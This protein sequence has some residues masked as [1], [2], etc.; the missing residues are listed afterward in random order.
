M[1]S[2]LDFDST[3][4]FRKTLIGRTL[5]QPNGPQT[6]S[7]NNYAYASLSDSSD[8]SGGTIT[9]SKTAEL[10]QSQAVNTYK[11]DSYYEKG[12]Q[13]L[14]R[15]ANL[16]LYPYFQVSE[17]NLVGILGNSD[18]YSNES[19]LYKFAVSNILNNPAGPVQQRIAQNINASA[20]GYKA[21]SDNLK[22]NSSTTSSIISGKQPLVNY[23]KSIT[24]DP[25]SKTDIVDFLEVLEGHKSYEKQIP[26][27]Y[28]TDPNNPYGPTPTTKVGK[29]VQ[30]VTGVL[31]AMLGVQSPYML[32]N[33]PSD[34][35]Y[36]YMGETQKQN[37]LDNLSYNRYAPDYSDTAI[38]IT[39]K[40][41]SNFA[42]D[43]GRSILNAVGLGNPPS[44]A[45]IG[46]DR[47][48]SLYYAMNDFYDRPVLSTYYLSL[49]F[50]PTQARLL[51]KDTN[52]S[53]GG[54][55]TG[56]LTWLSIN[57]KKLNMLGANNHEWNAQNSNYEQTESVNFS[58]KDG[59]ILSKTQE[60]LD[61]LPNNGGA[62]R[63][64]VANAIDQT[65]RI[66]LDGDTFMARGSAVQYTDQ[67]GQHKGVEYCRTWTKDRPY[68]TYDNLMPLAANNNDI[69]RQLYV[70]TSKPY[71]RTNVRRYDSSVMSNTWNLNIAPMSDGNKGFKD[72]TNIFEKTPGKEDFYAKKYMFSIENLA[73]K[74]SNI[75]GFTV[76]D[77]PYA[78]VGPNGGRVMW[79]APYDL[80]VTE[81]NNA[82]W[83]KN[84]FV[85]RPEPIYTY[86][87]TE[88]SGTLSFK[89]VVDHPSILNLLVR[90][91]FKGVP[92]D[93]ADN[94]INAYFAGCQDLDFYTLVRKYTNINDTDIKL[95][96]AYLNKGGDPKTIIN[97]KVKTTP[98]STKPQPPIAPITKTV[99]QTIKVNMDYPNDVPHS[100]SQSEFLPNQ[101]YSEIY[102]I[103]S[104]GEFQQGSI[105]GLTEGMTKISQSP[106]NKNKNDI[107]VL[108]GNSEFNDYVSGLT[109]FIDK[110]TSSLNAAFANTETSYQDFTNGL[111]KI[112]TD[113]TDGL[114]SGQTINVN[115]ESSTSL[116]ADEVYNIKLSIRRSYSIISTF[117]E[118]VSANGAN[119]DTFSSKWLDMLAANPPL[120]EG[121]YTPPV[122][123]ITFEELGYPNSN[124]GKFVFK[125]IND[126]PS[127]TLN[128]FD[129][130]NGK[131]YD[132][133]LKINS[134][135]AYGCRQSTVSWSYNEVS[136]INHPA[137][138]NNGAGG[139]LPTTQIIEDGKIVPGA[140]PHKPSI[141]TIKKIIGKTLQESYY[142]KKIEETDPIVF[143][144]LK[145]K[146][147]Y[148]HPAFHSTTP[149]GLNSRLTFLQ[150]CLR[151]GDTIPVST[152]ADV[153]DAGARN[154]SFGPPP[155]CVLR[156][157]DF[158]HSK[159]IIENMNITYDDNNWDL[160]PDGIGVQP[161]IATVQLSIK[162][163]GGQ[164]LEEPVNRLQNALSSNFYA[165]TEMYDDRAID[166]NTT[167]GGQSVT[168]FTKTFLELLVGPSPAAP[169]PTNVGTDS[170]T[171]QGTYIGN[172]SSNKID[173]K[174]LIGTLYK[175]V[176]AYTDAYQKMY[177]TLLTKYGSYTMNV[178]LSTSIRNYIAY[179]IW[180]DQGNS[181][182]DQIEIFGTYNKP[183]SLTTYIDKF[184]KTLSTS[185]EDLTV[186]M[187]CDMFGFTSFLTETKQEK[188]YDIL[189]NWLVDTFL[190]QFT[191][192]INH[193]TTT[194]D[195]EKNTRNPLIT[196]LDKLNFIT[197]YGYDGKIEGTVGTSAILDL[198]TFT[199]ANFYTFYGPYVSYLSYNQATLLS[200]YF[201]S[202]INF[203]ETSFSVDTLKRILSEILFDQISTIKQLFANTNDLNNGD[204]RKIMKNIEAFVK[205]S[206]E[207]KFN[208]SGTLT[209]TDTSGA[210]YDVIDNIT[211]TD[212]N[213]L[214]ELKKINTNAA[215]EP[216]QG[217]LNYY[218]AG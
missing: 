112:K 133:D 122:F 129:C 148:F 91:Y 10:K 103:V 9:V 192:N 193:D 92:D 180:N 176:G 14:P 186:H 173:Y 42:A 24:I 128:G 11:P 39:P 59:S 25:N 33:K 123:T 73:W 185:V 4:N 50:D 18:S 61:T 76:Q 19:A 12:M 150:Q 120:A 106:T 1:P 89:V 110:Q 214:D 104:S 119:G 114:V 96:L 147:K 86:Q 169:K 216:N 81:Q 51:H 84:T 48:R 2:Y 37:L 184:T 211:I 181:A 146:L 125:T 60:I 177:N 109:G 130:K 116:V 62:A 206:V 72:S 44:S 196:T 204:I 191:D 69:A 170:K 159:V 167:I 80:K 6:F 156:I 160:N 38:G 65:S 22:G 99:T 49:F 161:M 54:R 83:E 31:G 43:L 134:P 195:F 165:N 198:T 47:G 85:G 115:I 168:A 142:F 174:D 143:T 164:G 55:V 139:R 71:R 101:A 213:T 210:S 8:I 108:I 141:D 66:F 35:F 95:I 23:T 53:E 212:Q 46:D 32:A 57:S 56:N 93:E 175:Q 117:V 208:I 113:L 90:E 136:T 21:L 203:D 215:V 209:E 82:Q 149:E 78:E 67:F 207:V 7:K 138:N 218:K 183:Y 34:L 28:L 97:Y 94:Y 137:D 77:L 88:R 157:G 152:N 162:F 140:K 100:K 64:H 202:T 111:E 79:F 217:T 155:V 70:P 151:P 179:D 20:N 3:N 127:G 187:F 144:S 189:E 107:N 105:N 17:H 30:D 16:K 166:T 102:S 40:G 87:Y 41:K 118:K 132:R 135:I 58:F 52:L 121:V 197:K 200:T 75:P 13:V 199:S 145:E 188:V 68:Y 45:Y 74:T 194:Q 171:S 29:V 182:Q 153:N 36:Q 172:F 126:G 15:T 201:D 124:G 163:L 26:G 190:P 5:Q 131:F 178:F 154:T 63:A 98:P 205:K 158:Y 27:N